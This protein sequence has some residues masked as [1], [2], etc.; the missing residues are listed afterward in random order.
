MKRLLIYP[1]YL[2]QL[3]RS[4][5]DRL[6]I[7][8][9]ILGMLGIFLLFPSGAAAHPLDEFYQSTLITI[10][11]NR[12]TMQI[13]L[14]TG[15]L[16]APQILPM[17]DINQDDI[18]SEAEGQAYVDL[19]LDDVV[20]EIDGIATPMTAVDIEM[21]SALDSKAGVGV[22]RF[23]LYTNLPPDHRGDHQ[24]FL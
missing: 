18:I 17:I 4:K 21:P 23:K 1:V 20:F 5:G 10:V 2:L 12:I 22:I 13:E 24:F 14:Y 11:P 9:A 8:L 16:V 6:H 7:R 3:N 19:F 15:V